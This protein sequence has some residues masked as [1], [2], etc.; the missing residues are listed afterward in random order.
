MRVLYVSCVHEDPQ[1][2]NGKPHWVDFTGV[3]CKK[4]YTNTWWSIATRE[5]RLKNRRERDRLRRQM[6]TAEEREARF[7]IALI[8]NAV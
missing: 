7:I 2:K 6:E 3:T 4:E 8:T 1:Y 5:E